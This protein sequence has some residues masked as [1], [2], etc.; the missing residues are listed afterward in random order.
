MGKCE[1]IHT[2]QRK[3]PSKYYLKYQRIY[4]AYLECNGEQPNTPILLKNK[5]EQKKKTYFRMGN[6]L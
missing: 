6:N 5:T 4:W 1:Q 3:I 2:S